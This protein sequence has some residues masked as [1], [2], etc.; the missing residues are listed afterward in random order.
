MGHVNL[1]TI[2]RNTRV[3]GYAVPNFW[4][5]NV[6]AL[7]GHLR[8]AEA[9]RAPIILCYN[10]GL[11]PMLPIEIG[12][13]LIVKAA[14]HAKVPVATILDHGSSLEMVLKTIYYG[15]SSVMFDGSHLSYEENV[16]RT[17]EV[18]KVAKPLGI[19][20]EGELGAIGGSS[21]EI[22]RE[23]SSE[24]TMTDPSQAEDFVR[25]TGIDALA[26]SFGNVHG[27]YKGVPKLNLKLLKS[28]AKRVD[29]PLVMHGGS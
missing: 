15:I 25:R 9:K 24:S 11:C 2:L 16:Y 1:K 19:S 18:V 3:E 6:E 8:A 20:V 22:G 10:Y 13:P 29:V 26:I 12:V 28:I 23:N 14:E 17:R 4:G 5:G 7:L 27:K 21:I